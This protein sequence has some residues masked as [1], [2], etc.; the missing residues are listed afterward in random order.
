MIWKLRNIKE[1]VLS[2]SSFSNIHV[3]S[4]IGD[5]YK[6]IL[7]VVDGAVNVFEI[8]AFYFI[9]IGLEMILGEMFGFIWNIVDIFLKCCKERVR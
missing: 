8:C 7:N 3:L 2:S 1:K 4:V 5:K 6:I 9:K